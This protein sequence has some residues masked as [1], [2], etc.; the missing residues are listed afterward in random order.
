[1]NFSIFLWWF[2]TFVKLNLVKPKRLLRDKYHSRN[3]TWM[4]CILCGLIWIERTSWYNFIDDI[5]WTCL[6]NKSDYANK[7][8]EYFCHKNELKLLLIR[9]ILKTA[10]QRMLKLYNVSHF[11]PF[12]HIIFNVLTTQ[13]IIS[14]ISTLII[15]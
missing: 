13:N 8:N 12:L 3:I 2:W 9:R 10:I 14:H 4:F 7:S 5:F 1:M 11:I 6:G 15:Y